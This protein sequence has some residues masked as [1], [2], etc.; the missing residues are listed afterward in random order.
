M[1]DV[2]FAHQGTVEQLIGDEIVVL[3]GLTEDEPDA[4]ARGRVR[5]A[6]HGRRRCGRLAGALGRG[7]PAAFDI[8]VGI[9]SGR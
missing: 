5:R 6:R 8:G 7:G 4:A 3:F 9:S 1:I 2:I